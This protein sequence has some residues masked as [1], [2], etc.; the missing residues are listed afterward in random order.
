MKT[1]IITLLSFFFYFSANSQVI[2]SDSIALVA[3]Y[4]ATGGPDWTDNSNWLSN[5]PVGEWHGIT[6]SDQRVTRITLYNN[7]LSGAL[8]AEI[9]NLTGLERIAISSSFLSGEIP[10]EIGQCTELTFI[11]FSGNVL[12]GSFPQE[13]SNC[14]KLKEIIVYQN[15]FSG[16]FPTVL[17]GLP[18]LSRLELGDNNFSGELPAALS[19]ATLL[20]SFTIDRN[21]FTGQMVSLKNLTEMVEVHLRGNNLHG[22]IADIF[23]YSPN[24]Y[25]LSLGDNHFTGCVSDTFFNPTK[26]QFFD[27]P[28]NDFDCVGDFSHFADTGVIKRLNLYGNQIPFE[29]LEPNVVVNNYTYSPQQTLLTTDTMTLMTGDSVEIQSGSL[30]QHTHYNWYKDGLVIAG[31]TSSTL[32]VK[33]FDATKSGTYYCSMTNDS[34]PL[35]TLERNPVTL[36]LEGASAIHDPIA[37]SLKITPNPVDHYILLDSGEESPLVFIY[38][39]MGKVILANYHADHGKIDVSGFS[40]GYYILMLKTDMAI[41]SG[42]FYKAGSR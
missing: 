31:E 24:M 26:L 38:D 16:S 42:R 12:T 19:N 39:L 3:F 8:P 5:S 21:D 40:E 7:N 10:V 34:L 22:D 32:W 13:I 2:E 9:G 4:N 41:S 14:Q 25:Y 35:L 17:L 37:S 33:D 20:R 29:Y 11:D 27:F 15:Q 36:K 18:E 6:L 23:N 1:K 30:G 28:N